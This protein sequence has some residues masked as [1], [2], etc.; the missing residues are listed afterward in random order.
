MGLV[1]LKVCS[2]FSIILGPLSI[3]TIHL[4]SNQ[5]TFPEE[6]V[7]LCTCVMVWG[8]VHGEQGGR[9]KWKTLPSCLSYSSPPLELRS[10]AQPRRTEDTPEAERSECIDRRHSKRSFREAGF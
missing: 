9:V 1:C 2:L 6:G 3:E 4:E 7:L 5:D 10:V 8:S